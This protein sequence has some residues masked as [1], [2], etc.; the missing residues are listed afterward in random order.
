M[1]A[2]RTFVKFPPFTDEI[3][4]SKT[5]Q[6]V[7]VLWNPPGFNY[8]VIVSPVKTFTRGLR[9]YKMRGSRLYEA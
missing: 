7:A 3:I 2:R 4:D 1:D 8:A 5:P 6:N 9:L